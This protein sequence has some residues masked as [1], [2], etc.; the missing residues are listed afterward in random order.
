V[1]A[2]AAELRALRLEGSGVVDLA[3]RKA[4]R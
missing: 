1:S 4:K 3:D 2:L